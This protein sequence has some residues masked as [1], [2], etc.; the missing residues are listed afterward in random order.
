MHADEAHVNPAAPIAVFDSGVGGLSVLRAIRERLPHE[1]LL[2]VADSGYAPYGDRDIAFIRERAFT[3]VGEL[4]R[5][6]A[7]SIVIA[8]NTAT[9]VAAAELRTQF[10]LPIIA[11]EP[12]IK[13]AVERSASHVIGVL[14]TSRTLESAAVARLCAEY[15]G[16]TR[17][18]LQACPG[19]VECVERGRIDSAETTALLEHYLAGPL[20]AG[21]DTLVLGCTHYAFLRDRIQAIVGPTVTLLDSADAVARQTERRLRFPCTQRPGGDETFFTTGDLAEARERISTL[22]GSRVNAQPFTPG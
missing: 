18:V 6:G 10:A 15:G 4:V 20:A 14:A 12:A 7:K 2:Y 11:L 8:C 19:L 3:I 17:I 16:A 1:P 13:P 21:A 9:V 5:R 22:W